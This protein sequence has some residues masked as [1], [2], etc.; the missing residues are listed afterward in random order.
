[1]KIALGA[2]HRGAHVAQRLLERLQKEGHTVELLGELC[3]TSCDYPDSA[4][5]V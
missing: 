2:D 5:L 4:Y 1:M 3:T